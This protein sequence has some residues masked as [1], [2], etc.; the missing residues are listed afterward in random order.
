MDETECVCRGDLAVTYIPLH[1]LTI[2]SISLPEAAGGRVELRPRPPLDYGFIMSFPP[3]SYIMA[4]LLYSKVTYTCRRESPS[5]LLLARP[6][7]A[8]R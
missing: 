7:P 3:Y 2:T 5:A 8:P 6:V 1:A 4:T